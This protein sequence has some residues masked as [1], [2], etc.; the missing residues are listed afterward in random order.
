MKKLEEMTMKELLD[1][2]STDLVDYEV[3]IVLKGNENAIREL[4]RRYK[5]NIEK[6]IKGSSYTDD[7]PLFGVMNGREKRILN[8]QELNSKTIEEIF[9]EYDTSIDR[10]ALILLTLYNTQKRLE[11]LERDS[12][13]EFKAFLKE[14]ISK[15]IKLLGKK[16]YT[17]AVPVF[18]QD[19]SRISAVKIINAVELI[20][21]IRSG[22]KLDAM[23]NSSKKKKQRLEKI[24]EVMLLGNIVQSINQ[25][26]F[27]DIVCISRNI[28]EALDYQK[29]W[30][31]V[32]R[33]IEEHPEEKTG[34]YDISSENISE[35]LKQK[36]LES[37]QY[38]EEMSNTIVQ[39]CKYIDIDKLLLISAYRYIE[40]LENN[41]NEELEEGVARK[42]ESA[43]KLI[44][45][46]IYSMKNEISQGTTIEIQLEEEGEGIIYTVDD[47]SRDLERIRDGKYISKR[48]SEELK[49]RI[50]GNEVTLDE[51]D[52]CD[53]HLINFVSEDLKTMIFNSDRNI[54]YL[55]NMGYIDEETLYPLICD[56]QRCSKEL[57]Q[58]AVQKG[59]LCSKQI[60]ELFEAGIIS[61]EEISSITN[62]ELL[63]IINEDCQ[64]KIRE[65]SICILENAQ[66]DD[67]QR[68]R[69]I[70]LFNKYAQLYK[71]FNIIGK[72]QEEIEENSFRLVSSYEDNLDSNILIE[73]YQFGIISLNTAAD[74]G[75]NLSEMLSANSIKPTDLKGLYE[76]GTINI[77]AIKVVLVNTN[78]PYEEKLDLIYSTFDGE[79]E[80]EYALREELIE[81]LETGEE[82]RAE[83][84]SNGNGVRRSDVAIQKKKEFI[85][86]PHAR[87]KL[88]SL[89]DKD[90][91]KK[92]LPKDKEVVDGHRVFLLPNQDKVVIE[93]MHEKRSGKKAVAY[94]SATYVMN[95][96][97][98]F[99][100]ME[101]IIIDGAIN[102]TYLR[103]LFEL[104]EATKIIHTAGWGKAI[105][106]YFGIN[107]ENER[108]TK[109]ERE[110]IDR[111]VNNVVKSR[112][113]R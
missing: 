91:S 87:W 8:V 54:I 106:K 17:I 75:V 12:D 45:I 23:A 16:D 103:E 28:G 60:N 5:Q 41:R 21:S 36:I 82:Y 37:P 111:A 4:H 62:N 104:D 55:M 66:Q 98:F 10:Y 89:L 73:L 11:N 78:L 79:S 38:V 47:L 110:E 52:E 67:S 27:L 34:G 7:M 77:E 102:R 69:Q 24:E 76:K 65:L 99:N 112:K 32:A 59:M 105:K 83:T 9:A 15:C 46:L 94:G 101:N 97:S 35:E 14:N 57:F 64:N 44:Q 56:T 71:M 2:I 13:P 50:L 107:E 29:S 70:E 92:F 48:E 30:N 49:Q 63:D 43:I 113:E 88:I 68:M 84:K 81:L 6:I 80:V 20:K 22:R 53:L 100:H 26:D 93:R 19:R 109:E 42:K 90:Y 31:T 96:D 3:N 33:Y 51:V 25:E 72:S 74:W 86:D 39:N 40:I 61:T 95:T 58:I 108:Y 18:E 85:T 1:E